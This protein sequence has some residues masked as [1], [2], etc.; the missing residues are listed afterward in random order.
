MRRACW[1][2]TR[3][4][5]TNG[6]VGCVCL[7]TP[8]TNSPWPKLGDREPGNSADQQREVSTQ[9][10]VTIRRK[11]NSAGLLSPTSRSLLRVSVHQA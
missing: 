3:H 2:F 4:P 8:A 11:P 5:L 1:T 6:R 7:P 9:G 10:L